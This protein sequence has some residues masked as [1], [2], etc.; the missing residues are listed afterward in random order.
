[1]QHKI[2]FNIKKTPTGD[3]NLYV[4]RS[5]RYQDVQSIDAVK[6]LLPIMIINEL[7]IP[8]SAILDDTYQITD[9]VDS[10]TITGVTYNGPEPSALPANEYEVIPEFI[11]LN[12][13]EDYTSIIL[14]PLPLEYEG[15]LYYY[16]I[17]GVKGNFITHLSRVQA[18][19][20]KSDYINDGVREIQACNNYTGSPTDT[21]ENL[22]VCEWT[23]EIR[24][25]WLDPDA[26][27]ERFFSPFVDNIKIFTPDEITAD[28]RCAMN[29]RHITLKFPN[30]W[31]MDNRKYNFRKI[32]AFRI[33]NICD[34]QYGMWSQP[35]YQE[36]YPAPVERL[37]IFMEDVTVSEDDTDIEFNYDNVTYTI[38]RKYG[39]YYSDTM[40]P[41]GCDK[42]IL[43]Q[44]EGNEAVFSNNSV[45]PQ[46]MIN[47]SAEG[48]AKYKFT[49]YIQD[50]YG[51][52]SSPVTKIIET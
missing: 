12:R 20:L 26:T 16:S 51:Q 24:L 39:R 43:E 23:R 45:Q 19:V 41:L 36:E 40:I 42:Y 11:K 31:Q 48:N 18:E 21:W 30:V 50:I 6:N 9:S 27:H 22:G 7:S 15:V 38:T 14:N 35:T 44:Y 25:G 2:K 33:R 52:I 1:M 34:G 5:I 28:T 46:I 49:F 47:F 17:I 10:G 13:H 8:D 4:Y 3:F 37:F 29:F 32:K